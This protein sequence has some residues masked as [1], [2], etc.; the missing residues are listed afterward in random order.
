MNRNDRIILDQKVGDVTGDGVPDIVV[1]TGTKPFGSDTP[2]VDQVVLM[3]TN[4]ATGI[5]VSFALPGSSGY[6]PTLYLGEFTGNKVNEI[7]VRSNSGGSGGITYDFLY[8]YLNQSLRLLFDQESFYNAFSYAVNYLHDYQAKVENKTL[9]QTY[10]VSL[11][12]KGKEY[13][14]EIYNED[15]T[16]KVPIRG[17]VLPPGGVYPI[18][19]QRDGVDEL[20]IYQRVIG[21]YNADGLGFLST[22]IQWKENRFVPMYQAL[23]IFG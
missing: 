8:S 16:L 21:R 10:I 7:L 23:C 15:G 5:E 22:P 12:Y 1:L 13:L 14:S 11:L 19:L 20:L 6:N 18:D 9:Q 4:G 17:D 3:I 2:F